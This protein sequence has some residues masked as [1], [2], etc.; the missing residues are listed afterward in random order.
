M[1]IFWILLG[2]TISI[3]SATFPFGGLKSPG[4]ALLPIACGIILILLGVILLLQTRVRKSGSSAKP[5]GRLFPQGDA[6]RRV[7]LTLGGMLLSAILLVP[8][9]FA[10]TVFLLLL[11]LMR[12][13]QPQTWRVAVFY[14]FVSASGS[15]IVF[16]VLLKSQLPSGFLGF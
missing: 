5:S 2:L 6:G 4:P 9:G 13:I 11:F 1:A 16:K 10:L 14:A 7:V 3:W 12:A 8:L 15:F